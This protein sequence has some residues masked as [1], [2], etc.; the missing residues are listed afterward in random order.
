MNF[1]VKVG[2]VF[3]SKSNKAEISGL[4]LSYPHSPLLIPSRAKGRQLEA[5]LPTPLAPRKR[6]HGEE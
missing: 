4:A 2:R 1:F 6:G 3:L 5:P